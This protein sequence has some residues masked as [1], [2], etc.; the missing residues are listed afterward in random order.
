MTRWSTRGTASVT[1]N[2]ADDR[3]ETRGGMA[4]RLVGE[5]WHAQ[6]RGA[7]PDV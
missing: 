4:G 7:A 3:A 6:A 5:T 1:W 2:A